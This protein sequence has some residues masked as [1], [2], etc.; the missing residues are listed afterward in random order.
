MGPGGQG[1][2]SRAITRSDE[3]IP[4]TGPSGFNPQDQNIETAYNYRYD[5]LGNLTQDAEA[6]ICKLPQNQVH[7]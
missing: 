2:S 1:P 6:H 3:D 5:E 4:Y 7:G